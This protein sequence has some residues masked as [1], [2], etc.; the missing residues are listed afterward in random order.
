MS[1]RFIDT[2]VVVYLF[3]SDEPEKQ[4]TAKEATSGHAIVSTQVINEFANVMFRKFKLTAD[5]VSLACRELSNSFTVATVTTETI[6]NALRLKARYGFS[7]FDS[8][9]VASA[10]EEGC[11]TLYTEDLQHGQ[12]I[13]NKL[14]ITNP[15]K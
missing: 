1:T 9:I 10:L 2:N 8:L 12:I 15:F 3:S 6:F 4:A 14:T 7:Y 11:A 5:Q 13:E